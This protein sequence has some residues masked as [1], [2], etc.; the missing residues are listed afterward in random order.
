MTNAKN[1]IANKD[2]NSNTI[3]SDIKSWF[4]YFKS[5]FLNLFVKNKISKKIPT[6]N[7]IGEFSFKNV[8]KIVN[9]KDKIKIFK[10]WLNFFP[11]NTQVITNPSDNNRFRLKLRFVKLK[12][13]KVA[14]IFHIQII[15]VRKIDDASK[16]IIKNLNFI[17]LFSN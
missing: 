2:K 17:C 10:W 13:C 12:P 11:I 5:Y 7:H 9:D 4:K 15:I 14:N 16:V 6:E 1:T 8:Y 3:F